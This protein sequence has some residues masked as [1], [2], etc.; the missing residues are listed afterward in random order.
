MA[1]NEDRT[2]PSS[3]P[4]SPLTA[5]YVEHMYSNILCVR[6]QI[7]HTRPLL[8]GCSAGPHSL[9]ALHPVPDALLCYAEYA[10]VSGRPPSKELCAEERQENQQAFFS[11][12]LFFFQLMKQ[13][14]GIPLRTA[15][16]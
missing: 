13:M 11:L 9:G 1:V 6:V 4:A 5:G 14:F 12:P 15:L 8:S 2:S 7:V 16:L 10:Q 3:W